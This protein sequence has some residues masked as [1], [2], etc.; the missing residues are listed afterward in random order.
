[1]ATVWAICGAGRGVGKTHLAAALC[2]ALPDAVY[3]KLGGGRYHA[4]KPHNLVRTDRELEAFLSE[5]EAHA[6]IVAETNRLA[7]RIRAD[8]IIFVDSPA[9]YE[10]PRSD[11][12]DLRRSAHIVISPECSTRGWRN[13]LRNALGDSALVESVLGILMDQRRFLGCAEVSVRTKVWFAAGEQRVFGSGLA[14]L[15]AGIGRLGSLSK[16]ARSSGISYRKAWNLVKEAET[17]LG[18]RLVEP[19]VG[20]THGGGCVLSC[21]GRRLLNA[22]E[23]LNREVAAYADGRFEQLVR[24]QDDRTGSSA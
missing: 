12:D 23:T 14:A 9:G 6:H 10:N 22:F 1:M 17:A 19:R 3:V 20:G 21:D 5:H 7:G 4:D 24:A 11:R 8:V 2:N 18:R 15:L 13:V 16:A